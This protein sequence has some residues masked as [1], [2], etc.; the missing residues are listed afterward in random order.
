MKVS[1]D[2]VVG[3]DGLNSE[4][5]KWLESRVKEEALVQTQRQGSA[6]TEEGGSGHRVSTSFSPNR[7]TPVCLNSD[8]AGLRYKMITLKN[9]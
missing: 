3:A 5:R 1:P 9:R 8:A 6:R 2:L 4:V 7:F